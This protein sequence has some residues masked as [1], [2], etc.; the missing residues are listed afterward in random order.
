VEPPEWA[1]RLRAFQERYCFGWPLVVA[2]LT[3]VPVS[4][5]ASRLGD[6]A[7]VRAVYGREAWEAGLRV[8]DPKHKILS[9][10]N[11]MSW[12]GHLVFWAVAPPIT[13]GNFLVCFYGLGYVRMRRDRARPPAPMADRAGSEAA[14]NPP[15]QPTATAL[16]D[17]AR[18]FGQA[19]GRGG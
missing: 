15:L 16:A 17:P 7:A 13:F 8:I 5:Y 14:P 1:Q 10:G 4:H 6:V 18:H 9:D 3:V 11:K 19:G 2:V 12:Q